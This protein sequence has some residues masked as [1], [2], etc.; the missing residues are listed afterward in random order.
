MKESALNGYVNGHSVTH[1]PK[2]DT[3]ITFDYIR[4]SAQIYDSIYRGFVDD[5]YADYYV[6]HVIRTDDILLFDK[7]AYALP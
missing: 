1:I 2:V 4:Y 7:E 3:D 5:S 6:Y